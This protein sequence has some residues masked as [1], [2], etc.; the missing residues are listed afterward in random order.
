[1][2][3]DA[4]VGNATVAGSAKPC[5]GS[6]NLVRQ[7][8]RRRVVN[9][10]EEIRPLC[11]VMSDDVVASAPWRTLSLA[12]EVSNTIRVAILTTSDFAAAAKAIAPLGSPE[13]GRQAHRGSHSG[14]ASRIDATSLIN[15]ATGT[16]GEVL[17]GRPARD[18]V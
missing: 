17:R 14:D 18:A 12:C 3:G 15:E 2:R 16:G 10:A 7:L 8:S 11:E 5:A 13:L 9:G 6:S 1:M 4:A